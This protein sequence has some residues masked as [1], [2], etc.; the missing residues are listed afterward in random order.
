MNLT[1]L[2]RALRQLRLS[3]MADVVEARLR[4][5]QTASLIGVT[6]RRASVIRIARSIVS[7]STLTRR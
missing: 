7:I 6:N 4:H 5:A 2:D 1:E 3:G